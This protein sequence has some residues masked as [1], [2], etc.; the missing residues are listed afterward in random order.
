MSARL[1]VHSPAQLDGL[2]RPPVRQKLVYSQ[3]FSEIY[4]SALNG[5]LSYLVPSTVV[6][7]DPAATVMVIVGG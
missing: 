3:S 2:P 4:Q 5:L 7:I 1:E 6:M